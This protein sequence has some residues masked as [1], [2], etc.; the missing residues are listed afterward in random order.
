MEWRRSYFCWEIPMA[1]VFIQRSSLKALFRI[2][3]SVRR[4]SSSPPAIL[5]IQPL[6]PGKRRNFI[7]CIFRLRSCPIPK[8]FSVIGQELVRSFL[9]FSLFKT[10]STQCNFV[11]L[12]SACF[13]VPPR[14]WRASNPGWSS[15]TPVFYSRARVCLL[16]CV[17][18]CLCI[19][20]FYSRARMRVICSV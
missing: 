12:L 6:G 14:I 4:F 7:S 5:H 19:R 10:R 8:D 9:L 3:Y 18:V 2:L 17:P 15:R 1:N 16:V 11:P 13:V 20:V